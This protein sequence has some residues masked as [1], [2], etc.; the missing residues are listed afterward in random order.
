MLVKHSLLNR[1]LIL[2][3][4][5]LLVAGTFAQRIESVPTKSE[6]QGP[7]G[8]NHKQPLTYENVTVHEGDL[9]I[10]GTQRF[11]IENCSYLQNGSIY[12]RDS[13]EL[14]IRNAALV[15]ESAFPEDMEIRS[16]D[17]ALV[18][19]ENSATTFSNGGWLR[20]GGQSRAEII[21]SQIDHPTLGWEESTINIESSTCI[22]P[23]FGGNTQFK[24]EDSTLY[25]PFDFQFGSNQAVSVDGLRPGLF[26]F[27]NLHVNATVTNVGYNVTLVN[28]YVDSW[29]LTINYMTHTS[30]Q[31]CALGR[32]VV[33]LFNVV[34]SLE[35]I[36]P[37]TYSSLS[38]GE[39]NLKN[40]TVQGQWVF[41]FSGSCLLTIA[42]SDLFF[43]AYDSS[44]LSI[45]DSTVWMQSYFHSGNLV[46]NQ[47]S[48][49]VGGYGFHDANCSISGNLSMNPPESAARWWF[50]SKITRNY[51]VIAKDAS[52]NPM[53]QVR[54]TLFDKQN[55]L[56]WSGFTDNQGVANFNVT[57]IDGNY[58]DALILKAIE[59]DLSDTKNVAFLSGT[60]VTLVLPLQTVYIRADGSV[61]PANAP[62]HRNGDIYTL[63]GDITSDA[64][65]VVIE[66]DNIILDGASHT[67]QGIETANQYDGICLF[68]RNNVTVKNLKIKGFGGG[69]GL[70]E[71][72]KI[73]L[74]NNSITQSSNGIWLDNSSDNTLHGNSLSSCTNYGLSVCWSANNT[75]SQNS[76]SDCSFGFTIWGQICLTYPT[77]LPYNTDDYVQWFDSSN[78]IDGKPVYYLV[79]KSDLLIDAANYP[80]VGYLTLVNCVNI[81]VTGLTLT[82][83]GQGLLLV[84][85]NSSKIIGN[86]VE[87]NFDGLGCVANSCN[88]TLSGNEVKHNDHGI[89]IN[90][91]SNGNSL[92]DNLVLSNDG[93]ILGRG[94]AIH[95]IDSSNNTL[96]RNNMTDN[97]YGFEVWGECL[98]HY[99]NDVDP[100]NTVNNKAVYYWVNRF[101][102]AVPSDAAYVGLVN[103]TNI[104]VGDLDICK[105]KQGILLAQTTGSVIHD[106]NIRNSYYGIHLFNSSNNLIFHNSIIQNVYQIYD[107]SSRNSAVPS[108][109]NTWNNSYP[110]GG[111][112]WGD[113]LGVDVFGGLCQYE[114]GSD[115]IGDT[116]YVIDATNQDGYPLMGPWT[117]IGEGVAVFH[118]SGVS[119][120]FSS[121][122]SNGIT[123][124]GQV[125]LGPVPPSGYILA[126]HPPF[127]YDMQTTASYS[128]T[129][130]FSISYD[131]TGL[132]PEQEINL[133]LLHWNETLQQWINITTHVDTAANI[134]YGETGSLSLF[135]VVVPKIL[136]GDL[137][138]DDVVDIFD[139]TIVATQFGRPPP[140]ITDSRAD[141]NSD[142]IVDIFDIVV[143]ALHFGETG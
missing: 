47:T 93:R 138:R 126:T 52:G 56:V 99:I 51:D 64:E 71:S 108:S 22:N 77:P 10:G 136:K 78:T 88:N 4:L 31:N 89:S 95:L 90:C 30:I 63:N 16:E 70:L 46:F 110:S 38:L 96:R 115:G 60:P 134:V 111:N 41:H 143:V 102:E 49:T 130:T 18:R 2:V 68:G 119:M 14:V 55:K 40:T 44:V 116:P 84:N 94:H 133:Q 66:R 97:Q 107:E 120:A 33:S 76:I 61:D 20:V 135:A 19:I 131:D 27:W 105:G 141:V 21:D 37:Q 32:I 132:I 140:P 43:Y 123:T 82:N 122:I 36:R 9:D 91:A 6:T 3:L 103:C 53:S 83:N 121:V 29:S 26:S 34:G 50:F 117:G 58:T 74:L 62:V 42:D 28:T 80:Q 11:T 57:F 23:S 24:I 106:S 85:T 125:Q 12:I 69:I 129:I 67:V 114:T 39:I 137:N 8:A 72:Q 25:G 142:G 124:I 45:V 54:L 75:F 7:C 65:G 17:A 127:Y 104:D 98:T 81:T 86:K 79:D 113:Y 139:I 15:V 73:F 112:Y 100:S 92:L 35:N 5:A 118:A 87:N 101:D 109:T 128:G 1:I 48:A 13:A 59:G